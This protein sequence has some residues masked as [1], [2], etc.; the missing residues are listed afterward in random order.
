MK[1]ASARLEEHMPLSQLCGPGSPFVCLFDEDTTAGP[2]LPEDFR[3]VYGRWPL[4]ERSDRSYSYANFVTSRDGRVSFNEPGKSGGGPISGNSAHD[5]WLM[6]LLRARADAVLVSA[7]EVADN[8]RH[9]WRAAAIF[10]D[11][12]AGWTALRSIEQRQPVPLHVVVTRRGT[13]RRDAATLADPAVPVLVATTDEGVKRA[14]ADAGDAPNVR[15]WSSGTEVD[16]LRLTRELR[17]AFGV[18]SLLT[19]AGPRIFGAMLA[20]GVLDDEFV[21]LSPIIAGNSRDRPRP[22]M[23]ED[24]AFDAED[25]PRSRPL[26]LLRAGDLLFLHSRYLQRAKGAP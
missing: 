5:R 2:D 11:D 25:A 21:T 8:A 22:G 16:F 14:Q 6:G 1:R 4:P 3:A 13:L 15:F 19:E 10:P 7:D 24:V 18:R 26:A 9:S 23:V 20:A 12:A 17:S